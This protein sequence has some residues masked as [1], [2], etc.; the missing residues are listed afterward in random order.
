MK[1]KI[2]GLPKKEPKLAYAVKAFDGANTLPIV[3]HETKTMKDASVIA[4][5]L[6]ADARKFSVIEMVRRT[7]RK[8]GR[9][10][11]YLWPKSGKVWQ[12]ESRWTAE[13]QAAS[14]YANFHL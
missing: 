7:N 14:K 13:N 12:I 6:A 1:V 11:R 3:V 4:E 5:N 10:W 9:P 2:Q 8:I